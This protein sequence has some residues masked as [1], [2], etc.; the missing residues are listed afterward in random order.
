MHSSNLIYI[1][2]RLR[3]DE[4]QVIQL[5]YGYV[6]DERIN[7][8]EF[9][10]AVGCNIISSNHVSNNQI[11]VRSSANSAIETYINA[12]FL[13]IYLSIYY[14]ISSLIYL[15]INRTIQRLK[16]LKH[17]RRDPRD[18]F[19]SFDLDNTGLIDVRKFRDINQSLQLLQS[20]YQLQRVL[21]DF[22][23]ISNKNV[24]SYEDFCN[25][26][27][28]ISNR[29]NKDEDKRTSIDYKNKSYNDVR[30]SSKYDDNIGLFLS[31]ISI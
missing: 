8:G 18:M 24:I 26:L 20:E 21:D 9:C 23:S 10:Q 11:N 16:E 31:N 29:N 30:A 25:E 28:R 7:Y 17:D 4:I 14:I 3:T 1:G 15:S 22:A 12:R 27:D 13:S 6:D 19:S 2:I 5:L